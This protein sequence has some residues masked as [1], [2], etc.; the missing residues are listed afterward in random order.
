MY[1]TSTLRSGRRA[2]MPQ[3]FTEQT[4]EVGGTKIEVMV[5]GAGDPMLV[6]HGSGGNKG[7]LQY[8]QSLSD[9]YQ[10]YAPS[11]PGFGNSERPDWLEGMDDLACFYSWFLEELGLEAVHVMGFSL[12]GW[13]AAEMAVMCPHTFKSI[14]LVDSAGI[15]PVQGEIADIFLMSGQQV[16]ENMFYDPE[17]SPEY[18][19]MYGQEPTPEH[20]QVLEGN[21]AMAARLTWKPYMYDPRLPSLLARVHAPTLIVW[22]RQDAIV[23]LECGELFHKA[24]IGSTL[25]VIENCGHTPQYEK[26]QEFVDTVIDFLG[27]A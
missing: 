20:R 13:L 7:W 8:L 24:M 9:H 23:P 19:K 21:R 18:A 12:G 11:H 2:G 4:V 27:K 3:A 17:Q 26:P 15:K 5:G 10:V 6:L 1:E 25:K 22:G 14:V 16:I